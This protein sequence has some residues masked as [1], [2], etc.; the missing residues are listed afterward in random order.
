MVDKVGTGAI[1]LLSKVTAFLKNRKWITKL[2]WMRQYKWIDAA[3]GE[4]PTEEIHI[5]D[6]QHVGVCIIAL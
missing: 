6:Y 5:P 3:V 2:Q 1:Q 4:F